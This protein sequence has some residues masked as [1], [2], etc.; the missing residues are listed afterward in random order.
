MPADL[1]PEMKGKTLYVWPDSLIAPI[2][3]SQVA[4]KEKGQD[5]ARYAEFWKDPDARVYQFLGQD[6]VYFYVLMQGAMWIGSQNDPNR[7]PVKGELQLTDIFGCFHLMVDGDKM[8]KSRG[9][10]YTGDQLLDEKGYS[11]EQIRYFLALLSLPEKGSNFDFNTLNERNK[12][13]AGPLNA[14]FEKPISACQSK[15]DG[16]VPEGTLNE[17]VVTDTTRMV[18]RYFKSMDKAQYSTLLFEIENYARSINSMFT[19]HKPHDDRHPEGE[20]KD[21]LFTCFYVL[22]NLMIM[23]YPFV[24]ATM[25]KL[26]ETLKLPPSVFSVDELG[27]PI[28]AGHAIG[29][30]QQY[31]PAVAE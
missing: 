6:N 9:N 21:A 22:K 8:S 7:M 5:A 14:A 16:R 18:A 15:F 20:R 28:P 17:K 29:E 1:D 19:Q 10:A 13:L 3:F 27:K 26:R 2:A 4:L 31:F 24:P 11:P 30:K 23:L 12:F 25:D